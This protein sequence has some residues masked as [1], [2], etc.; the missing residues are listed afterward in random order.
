MARQASKEPLD[1]LVAI[2][3]P[4][5]SRLIV[6]LLREIGIGEV[7]TVH[8]VDFA[9]L[10]FRHANKNFDLVICDRLGDGGNLGLLKFA[11]WQRDVLVPSLPIICIG[12]DWS[13][14]ELAANRDA[15]ATATL[16]LPITKHTLKVAVETAVSGPAVNSLCRRRSAAYFLSGA[17]R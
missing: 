12:T 2:A 3:Q 13:G 4:A 6:S 1:V 11:R 10:Q 14:D 8:S 9:L 15:G 16:A 7:T 17:H 5:V